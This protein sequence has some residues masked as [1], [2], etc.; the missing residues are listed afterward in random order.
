M[1]IKDKVISTITEQGCIITPITPTHNLADDLG[2]DSLDVVELQLELEQAFGLTLPDA[3][4]DN[5]LT[6]QDC[7]NLMDAQAKSDLSY[8]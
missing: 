8:G 3:K 5:V 7:I 4:W 2:F 6:V 1:T